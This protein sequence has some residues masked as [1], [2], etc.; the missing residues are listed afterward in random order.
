MIKPKGQSKLGTDQLLATDLLGEMY[1][2][3]GGVP[4][5]TAQAH[6]VGVPGVRIGV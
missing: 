6:E 5:N 3:D 4:Q 1:R 2:N